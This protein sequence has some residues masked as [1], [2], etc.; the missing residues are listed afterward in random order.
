MPLKT[1]AVLT[2]NFSGSGLREANL[3]KKKKDKTWQFSSESEGEW[4]RGIRQSQRLSYNFIVLL[5]TLGLHMLWICLRLLNIGSED[6]V[7][8]TC[9]ASTT[10]SITYHHGS[11]GSS[12]FWKEFQHEHWVF[13]PQIRV[14]SRS[15]KTH[16]A[17]RRPILNRNKSPVVLFF[18][19]F[20]F[21][22][23]VL[24][25]VWWLLL[26]PE[27]WGWDQIPVCFTCRLNMWCH[28]FVL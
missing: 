2:R 25:C 17:R 7:I 20:W 11:Y 18:G 4:G 16:D 24:G 28:V 19:K 5:E 15:P 27:T 13:C 26:V 9:H 14:M 1:L 10:W 22:T 23:L 12:I 3:P 6:Q 21:W 8:F